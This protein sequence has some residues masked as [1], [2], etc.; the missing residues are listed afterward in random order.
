MRHNHTISQRNKTVK[1]GWRK[2]GVA[3]NLKKGVKPY[4]GGGF[5]K[6]YRGGRGEGE[7]GGGGEKAS[8]N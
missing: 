2:G 8:V 4:R 7:G 3:Q 6:L 5:F 1:R